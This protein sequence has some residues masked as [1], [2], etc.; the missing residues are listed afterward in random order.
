MTAAPADGDARR[1]ASPDEDRGWGLYVHVPF[2]ARHCPYCDFD[3]VVGRRPDWRSFVDGLQRELDARA[4]RLPTTPPRTVYLGGGTPSLVGREGLAAVVGRVRAATPWRAL[5]E[6]TVELNPEHVDD[7]L[8]DGLRSLGVDRVSLGVQSFEPGALAQLGRVHDA[9][10][11]RHAVA[12]AI[13]ADLH[14]SIDLIVGY[15]GQS[16]DALARDLETTVALGVGHVSIYALDIPAA[17]PWTKLVRRGLR[18][19][20]DDDAQADALLACETALVGAGLRHYEVASYARPGQHAQHNASYWRAIDYVGLG[21]SAA[22]ARYD[23]DGA[24]HRRTNA[25]TLAAWSSGAPPSC[26]SLSPAATAREALWLGLRRLD[27]FDEAAWRLRWPEAA[28]CDR[29][30]ELALARGDLV[31]DDGG[32][33]VAA[34][35]WLQHD[36]IAVDLL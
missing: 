32:L 35:R 29:A 12:A 19:L 7:A 10:A 26:E 34:A 22:S 18:V 24:V 2:C 21:P 31:R 6:F 11:A 9:A 13:A 33:R 36:R 16:A 28:A 15:P 27:G 17:V 25:R 30:I 14:V 20:P 1:E 5:D 23:R 4:D 3:F 8:V